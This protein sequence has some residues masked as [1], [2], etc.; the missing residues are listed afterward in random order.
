MPTQHS[1]NLMSQL[2]KTFKQKNQKSNHN[3]NEFKMECKEMWRCNIHMV[4][5]VIGVT[6]V[7]KVK[8]K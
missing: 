8:S 1:L 5:V 7:S 3:A 4:Q 6:W 2:T